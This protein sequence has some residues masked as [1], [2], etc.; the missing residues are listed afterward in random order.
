MDLK[1]KQLI[2]MIVAGLLFIAIGVT[3]VLTNT[4]S[5]KS[6]QNSMQSSMQ[7]VKDVL[8]LSDGMEF[9]PPESDYIAVVDVVGTIGE[10][11]ETDMLDTSTGYRHTDTLAYI[12]ELMDDS[13]NKAV[14]L[15]VDSPGGTVYES[16][17][18]YLKLMEYKE[19]T[20]R[21]IWGYMAHYAASGGY[22]VSMAADRIFANPNT[23]T[24][25]IGV[26][27]SGYDLTGLYEKL[28]IR[29][30]SITSGK[31]KDSSQLTDEQIAIYQSQVDECYDD[32]V[33]KVAEGRKMS[34]G[35]VKKLADGRTYTAKQAEKNG[36]ID[37]ISLYPDM[38]DA[39]S[40]EIGV[41]DFY[42]P[43]T[44]ENPL[45]G[46][47]DMA[48]GLIPKSEAQILKETAAE[49]ESGVL[50]YYAEQLR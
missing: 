35:D 14:L 12:D 46:L 42:Q 8:Q 30:V 16:E 36:L 11:T 40:Q 5:Q 50:M 22:M 48:S 2:G 31:N 34:E 10:Q 38:Q 3:S 18:L 47:F 4:L 24:G 43:E 21:P 6:L 29:Y 49:T 32:F 23:V 19:A 33:K 41:T 44:N 37:E 7:G 9:D 27:M 25:S 1:K 26:I 13:N 28:G 15:Y 20:G 39:M 45:A 17:E